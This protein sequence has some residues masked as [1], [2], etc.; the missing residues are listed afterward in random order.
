V[1]QA[2]TQGLLQAGVDRDGQAADPVGQPGRLAGGVVVEPGEDFQL[3]EGLVAG[4]DPAQRVRQGAGSV[5][6]TRS[7]WHPIPS[8]QDSAMS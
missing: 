5:G 7:S 8:G 2:G 4:I 1:V 6:S 3:S